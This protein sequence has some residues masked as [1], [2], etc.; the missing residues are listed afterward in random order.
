MLNYV[1]KNLKLKDS[2][3]VLKCKPGNWYSSASMKKCIEPKSGI[4][5]W[6]FRI[7]NK[8]SSWHVLGIWK[9]DK[10]FEKVYKHGYGYVLS[11]GYLANPNKYGSFE[12]HMVLNV[13]KVML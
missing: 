4:H 5:S 8:N 11:E 7:D 2:I 10:E 6:T 3:T 12:G 9:L 1:I 13:K